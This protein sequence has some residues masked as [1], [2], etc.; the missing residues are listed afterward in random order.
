MTAK[1]LKA[2][3]TATTAALQRLEEALQVLK[4]SAR[5]GGMRDLLQD[6]CVKRFETSFEYVWK[7]FKVAA[8]NQGSEAPGPRPA[9]QEALRYGWID[10]P[11][12]WAEV[13][14][15]RNGSV[16]DYFGITWGEYHKMMTVFAE[17][18][19]KAMAKITS[20]E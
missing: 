20:I 6:A 3:V 17:R 19:R 13:L 8:E 12:F 16:H 7:L 1:K 9:I 11:G 18:T 2:A 4:K 5:E 10:H 15:A 14:D